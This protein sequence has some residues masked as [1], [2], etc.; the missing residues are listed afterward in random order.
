MKIIAAPAQNFGSCLYQTLRCSN[1]EERVTFAGGGGGG[2]RAL[3]ASP[4]STAGAAE[5][6]EEKI[7]RG[8]K[9]KRTVR[10]WCQQLPGAA[11]QNQ[12]K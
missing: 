1:P 7:R 11:G 5:T 12:E 6:T 9:E 3:S 10:R 2:Q 4:G 8:N